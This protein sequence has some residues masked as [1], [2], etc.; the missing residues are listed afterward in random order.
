[1]WPSSSTSGSGRISVKCSHCVHFGS[2]GFF[3]CGGFFCSI[4]TLIWTE[5]SLAMREYQ[6]LQCSCLVA[7]RVRPGP[8]LLAPP[9]L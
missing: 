4:F 8:A 9:A 2:V 3:V 6:L 5:C 7:Y 1:M